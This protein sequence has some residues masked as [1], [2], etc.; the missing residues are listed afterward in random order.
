[1]SDKDY[2]EEYLKNYMA[3]MN[4]Y[5]R[6][7]SKE[8]QEAVMR[9]VP[10]ARE[11]VFVLQLL[12]NGY[13]HHTCSGVDMM[14]L[15]RYAA[16]EGPDSTYHEDVFTF[17]EILSRGIETHELIGDSV[18]LELEKSWNEYQASL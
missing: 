1:M 16:G 5:Q 17:L 14:S 11:K 12:V 8:E 15:M 6:Q 10:Y 18:M 4:R 2:R 3:R 13:N 9:L 7:F